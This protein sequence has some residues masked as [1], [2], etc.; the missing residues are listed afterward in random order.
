MATRC[1]QRSTS[2]R[3]GALAYLVPSWGYQPVQPDD[4]RFRC[5]VW[6]MFEVRNTLLCHHPDHLLFPSWCFGHA[7]AFANVTRELVYCS[8]GSNFGVETRVPEEFTD[9]DSVYGH[10]DHQN[11]SPGTTKMLATYHPGRGWKS[12]LVGPL[13]AAIISPGP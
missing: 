8:I 12:H 2:L 13:V 11:N 10:Y 4:R 1:T 5:L 6:G 9:C 3:L 7:A